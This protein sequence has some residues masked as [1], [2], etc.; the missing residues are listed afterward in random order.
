[1]VWNLKNSAGGIFLSYITKL[2]IIVKISGMLKAVL[3]KKA[4]FKK[5]RRGN[6]LVWEG[7]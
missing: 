3:N 2:I 5:I 4:G 7:F 1:M 6:F